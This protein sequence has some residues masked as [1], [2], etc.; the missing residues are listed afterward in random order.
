MGIELRGGP[1]ELG[2]PV[3]EGNVF[4][5]GNPVCDD[6]WD[7]LDAK[8]ACRTLNYNTGIPHVG[9]KYGHIQ[10]KDLLSTT[11]AAKGRRKAYWTAL[12]PNG[13]TVALQRQQV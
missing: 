8:V 1:A 13:K 5:D 6:N 10:G 12:T 2:G 11:L 3:A 4:L 7:V 9:S